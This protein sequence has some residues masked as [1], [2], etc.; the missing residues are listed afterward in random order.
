MKK[1]RKTYLMFLGFVILMGLL[2]FG[3]RI[4]TPLLKD[5]SPK[6]L[7]PSE[8]AATI[9]PNSEEFEEFLKATHM[10]FSD[11]PSA[12]KATQFKWQIPK[13]TLGGKLKRIYVQKAT[14][15][16]NV[17]LIYD[18]G[19]IILITKEELSPSY[20]EIVKQTNEE[21][22]LGLEGK[23]NIAGYPDKDVE[24]IE[25]NGLE[26][27]ASEPGFNIIYGEKHS[28]PGFVNFWKEGIMYEIYG[29]S[30]ISLNQLIDVAK[31]MF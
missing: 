25:I 6:E 27:I 5:S 21:R 16:Q 15:P 24:L 12:E 22:K 30:T 31:S 14:L 9:M 23:S 1:F 10:M 20:K 17:V 19:F 26:G 8:Y 2:A 11:I 18:K 3:V 7:T 13:N 4:L 28:R 29:D